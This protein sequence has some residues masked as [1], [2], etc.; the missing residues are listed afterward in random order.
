MCECVWTR[1][2]RVEVDAAGLDGP[3]AV[4]ELPSPGG[5]S[6]ME[7]MMARSGADSLMLFVSNRRS[8][9][10]SSLSIGNYFKVAMASPSRN[11]EFFRGLVLICYFGL[12]LSVKGRTR[13]SG[14][15]AEEPPLAYRVGAA[16][17]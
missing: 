3:A 17:R 14:R 10:L 9:S 15:G 11:N 8:K 6:V 2:S 13:A 4:D 12:Y 1:G 7:D 16:E 5:G